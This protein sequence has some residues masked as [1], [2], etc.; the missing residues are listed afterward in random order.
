MDR[1]DAL[2]RQVRDTDKEILALVA[3][4]LKAA[5]EIGALKRKRGMPLRNYDV[6]AEVI[7]EAR[8]LC[9]RFHIDQELGEEIMR[10]LIKAAVQ[11]QEDHPS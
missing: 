4:R 8:R 6:E 3:R 5:Q 7:R 9:R 2:R 1:L 11:A 10:T